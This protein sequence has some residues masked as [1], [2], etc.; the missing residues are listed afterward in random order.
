MKILRCIH[1]ADPRGGGPIANIR[2]MQQP[3]EERGHRVELASLDSPD[4][5]FIPELGLPLHPLGPGRGSFGYSSRW[6]EWMQANLGNYDRIIIH[7]LWQYPHWSVPPLARKRRIPYFVYPH[8]MLDPW[9]NRR[10]PLKRIK[11]QLFW[12]LGGH[13]NLKG[14]EAVLFTSEQERLQARKSF[15]PY[16]LPE[17]VIVYGIPGNPYA[18][19]ELPHPLEG[20][21]YLLFLGR[22]HEKKG[23]DL[24]LQAYAEWENPTKLDLVIAGPGTLPPGSRHLTPDS[25]LPTPSPRLHTPGMVEGE[26]KWALLAHAEAFILPSHQENFGVAV[27]EALSAGTPV[28][29]SDQVNICREVESAGA[30]FVQPD[31]LEGTRNLLNAW[32]GLSA[33]R[34]QSMRR[35]ARE[36]FL[37]TFEV[38]KAAA[39]LEEKLEAPPAR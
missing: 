35:Q 13:R 17:Q 9:F 34:K 6:K 19:R 22:I 18:D 28:L 32:A 25:C 33:D 24:L 38:G 16:H 14:A 2:G 31:T 30:G 4:A 8:G 29:L 21:P 10:Y 37:S 26:R 7:G 20:R 1:S 39:D 27:A 23:I 36:R 15:W 5:P 12:W 3:L 11:K